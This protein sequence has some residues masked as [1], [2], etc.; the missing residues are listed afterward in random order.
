M[1]EMSE[2]AEQFRWHSF[3]HSGWVYFSASVQTYKAMFSSHVCFHGNLG[4][5]RNKCFSPN[6]LSFG[7]LFVSD[8]P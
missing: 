6:M 4:H 7:F 8:N 1:S 2:K 5:V 3:F